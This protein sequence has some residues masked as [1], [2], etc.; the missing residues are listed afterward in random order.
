MYDN[1]LICTVELPEIRRVSLWE[2]SNSSVRRGKIA[3]PREMSEKN[4][5]FGAGQSLVTIV[6]PAKLKDL[7]CHLGPLAEIVY[8]PLNK[9][10]FI[11]FFAATEYQGHLKRYELRNKRAMRE[12]EK[13]EEKKMFRSYLLSCEH[14]HQTSR[15]LCATYDFSNSPLNTVN[16]SR[17][18]D[19]R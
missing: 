16:L 5:E 2:H 15:R 18:S 3:I 19:T 8:R 11:D 12:G 13:Y 1:R 4:A 9:S 7:V 10:Y 14:F 17:E 6:N